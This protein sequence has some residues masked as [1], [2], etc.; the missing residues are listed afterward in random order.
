MC[1]YLLSQW[2][3]CQSV[4]GLMSSRSVKSNVNVS[5]MRLFGPLYPNTLGKGF[6]SSLLYP[7]DVNNIEGNTEFSLGLM[8]KTISE[9]DDF[10]F[11]PTNYR[12]TCLG[13]L[14]VS[15]YLTYLA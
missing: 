12:P 9:K 5:V 4:A 1:G 8:D 14:K 3:F 15:P 11:K 2:L 13:K 10:E 6:N 7:F